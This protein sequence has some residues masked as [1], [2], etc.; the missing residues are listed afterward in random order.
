MASR[1][2]LVAQHG[3][4]FLREIHVHVDEEPLAKGRRSRA[5]ESFRETVAAEMTKYRRRPFRGGVALELDFWT[6]ARNPPTIEAL[7][8]RYLDLLKKPDGPASRRPTVYFDDRQVKLLHV[9]VH[10]GWGRDDD[11]PRD[12]PSARNPW[13]WVRAMPL[14]DAVTGLETAYELNLR[15][16]RNYWHDDAGP[17]DAP[18]VTEYEDD[19]W[20]LT[21]FEDDPVHDWMAEYGRYRRR[22]QAQQP[23][24]GTA[25]A[26]LLSTLAS[27][28]PVL[29]YVKPGDRR[30][31]NDVRTPEYWRRLRN[32]LLQDGILTPFIAVPLA[33]LPTHSEPTRE[34]LRR[35]EAEIQAFRDRA[36]WL[37]PLARQLRVTMLV[38]PSAAARIST[39]SC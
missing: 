14:R 38:T 23:M 5:D 16:R 15:R 21:A 8:K 2:Y 35:V 31:P 12:L 20:D 30:R 13:V 29:Q 10:H 28:A 18:K 9:A 33:G 25:D 22:E 24:L 39:T 3:K 17:F 4:R 27:C 19:P 26:H 6:K 36:H 1:Q 34:F 7:A 11:K 37:F 32:H